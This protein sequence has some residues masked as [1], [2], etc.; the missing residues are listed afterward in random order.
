MMIRAPFFAGF[1]A[2]ISV[3]QSIFA[4]ENAPNSPPM[5]KVPD[6]FSIELAAGPP[7][8]E[9]PIVASFD[10][11]G[12][13]Y[14]AESSGSNDPVQKQLALRPHRVIRLEDTDGDGKFDK[15]T[16]FA[17]HMMFPEGAMFFDGSLYVSAPPSI[18]NLPTRMAMASPM[19]ASNGT[20]EKRSLA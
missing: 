16:V 4:E 13:L 1:L 2:L 7:L 9:R 19:S 5:P 18:G 3:V 15:R 10:D 8:V 17:D 20:K 11:E 12:R 14:V 6:G